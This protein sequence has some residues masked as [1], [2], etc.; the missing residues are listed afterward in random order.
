MG[1][2]GQV[3]RRE[4][5]LNPSRPMECIVCPGWKYSVGALTPRPALAG[6]VVEQLAD[7]GEL[8][9]SP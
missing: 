9:P 7:R 1:Q 6:E 5:G 2:G 4:A 3:F 8:Q